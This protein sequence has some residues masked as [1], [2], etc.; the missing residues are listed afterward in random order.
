MITMEESCQ[1]LLVQREPGRC[2]L[3]TTVD[4]IKKE[5]RKR[6]KDEQFRQEQE[7]LKEMKKIRQSK[8]VLEESTNTSSAEE[9]EK[10]AATLTSLKRGRKQVVTSEFAVT[11]DHN[12]ISDR[13]TV[14]VIG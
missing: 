3:M 11:L 5:A 6:K 10:Q 7:K 2:G 13:A 1:F 9:Q 12:M 8:A 14:Y 4:V